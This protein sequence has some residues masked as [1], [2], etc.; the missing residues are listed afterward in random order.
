[1]L[2]GTKPSET[3]GAPGSHRPDATPSESVA[4]IYGKNNLMQIKQILSINSRTQNLFRPGSRFFFAP[5]PPYGPKMNKPHSYSYPPQ[6]SIEAGPALYHRGRRQNNLLSCT[7]S[8]YFRPNREYSRTAKS[9]PPVRFPSGL[10]RI[11]D[12]FSD[13]PATAKTNLSDL[14]LRPTYSYLCI[15]IR[16]T[17]RTGAHPPRRT[18]DAPKPSF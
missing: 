7:S 11:H 13:T 1:M 18:W 6:H 12:L 8:A 9:K 15:L 14:F 3:K 2:N 4:A 16:W 17:I 5:P 10:I